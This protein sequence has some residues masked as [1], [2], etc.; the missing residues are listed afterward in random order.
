M[1]A[2]DD[3]QTRTDLA[4]LR[5]AYLRQLQHDGWADVTPNLLRL[6]D[7]GKLLADQI[8]LELFLEAP[9]S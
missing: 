8:T 3:P 2:L 4:A 5:A 9:A 1:P 7:R 6:T